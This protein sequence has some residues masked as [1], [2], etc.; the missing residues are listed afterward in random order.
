M[1]LLNLCNDMKHSMR[2]VPVI[3]LLML[4]H[5]CMQMMLCVP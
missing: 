3:C 1:P 4:A 2:Q 5:K